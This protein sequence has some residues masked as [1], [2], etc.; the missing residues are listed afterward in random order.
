MDPLF[1]LLEPW[2]SFKESRPE[3]QEN[4]LEQYLYHGDGAP[5][6]LCTN[7]PA[8]LVNS[9]RGLN[10]FCLHAEKYLIDSLLRHEEISEL[11]GY[12]VAK[13]EIIVV[14]HNLI[15]AQDCINSC[16]FK[17]A[18]IDASFK[19]L[20]E[21]WTLDHKSSAKEFNFVDIAGGPGGFTQYIKT[22]LPNATGVGYTLFI[23]WN[24]AISK[25]SHFRGENRDIKENY[26][27]IVDELQSS[28]PA[29]WTLVVADGAN[30]VPVET[31]TK[32][33]KLILSEVVIALRVIAIGGTLVLKVF[34]TLT[35]PMVDLVYL[36]SC[37]FETIVF[38][39]PIA[40]HLVNKERYLV[41][42]N[43]VT[44]IERISEYLEYILDNSWEDKIPARLV[45]ML[46]TPFHGSQT[47][48]IFGCKHRSTLSK[49]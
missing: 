16:Y 5:A 12:I 31:E 42:L 45:T 24:A 49:A 36:I 11:P 39:K 30:N 27:Q 26:R 34:T 28:R 25:L 41:C 2:D 38:F 19:L 40:S 29:G 35:Q 21:E 17:L 7:P 46:P 18:S 44:K 1:L 8:K 4:E 22:R 3:Y 20:Q 47:T 43:C 10:G 23:E 13:N 9:D 15:A 6:Q 37:F 32:N 14:S 48:I 33:W